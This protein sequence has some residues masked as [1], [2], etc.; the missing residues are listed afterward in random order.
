M[1]FTTLIAAPVLAGLVAGALTGRRVVPWSLAGLCLALGVAG[2]ATSAFNPDGRAEAITFS[3][4]ASVV[5][6]GLVWLG[7]GVGRLTRRGA[8]AA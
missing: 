7:F 8:R 3:L 1:F 2:A 4:V 6:A 5:C